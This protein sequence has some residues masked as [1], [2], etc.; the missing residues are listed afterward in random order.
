MRARHASALALAPL[1]IALGGCERVVDLNLPAAPRTLVVEARLERVVNNPSGSQ[2]IR[3]TTTSDYFS[4]S[5]APPAR[6]ATVTVTNNLGTVTTFT[7]S[8][9]VPGTYV[10]SNL[11]PV[12]G[13]SYTLRITF[14][15]EQYEATESTQPVAPISSLY[16][17]TPVPGRFSGTGGVRATIEFTDRPGE[18]NWYMWEQYVNGVRLQGPDSTVKL[19]T[20]ASDDGYD[21]LRI[22]DFQPYEGIDIP[23]GATVLVRQYALSEQLYRYFFA[24][25]DLLGSDGS[26]FAVPPASLRG[27][28]ANRTDSTR[29]ALGYFLVSEVSEARA[30]YQP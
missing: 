1:V 23:K 2:A 20:V 21:G 10:T 29:P 5:S 22:S 30:I 15:G 28:V 4:A 3:L 9:T 16:F 27:N 18:K 7:E 14:E 12:R 17:L 26:P 8:A 13:R 6:G 19:R 24:L 25:G 11:T